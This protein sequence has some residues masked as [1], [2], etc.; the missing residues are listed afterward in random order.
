[1][2]LIDAFLTEIN[3][4]LKASYDFTWKDLTIGIDIQVIG[5]ICTF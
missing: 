5:D 4:H 2:R 1:M 3:N